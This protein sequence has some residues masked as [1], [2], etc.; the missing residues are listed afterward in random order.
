MQ[1]IYWNKF[2]S[3]GKI[4]SYISYKQHI[5]NSESENNGTKS[6]YGGRVDNPRATDRR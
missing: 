3:D 1:D 4:E 2:I 5:K 6:V